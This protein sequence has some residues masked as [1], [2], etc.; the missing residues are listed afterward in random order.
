MKK[1]QSIKQVYNIGYVKGVTTKH[2]LRLDK[3]L[4]ILKKMKLKAVQRILDVGCGDGFFTLK[5]TQQL[6]A[7]ETFGIDISAAAVAEALKRN[8]K[9]SVLDIDESDLPYTSNYF[10]FI[11]CGNLIEVVLDPDHLLAELNRV[12]SPQ[13]YLIITFPNL[14]AW[15]SRIAVLLGFH[16]YFDRISRKYDLGKMFRPCT[17]RDSTGHINLYTLRSF[18][19]LTKIYGFDIIKVYG[20]YA[21]SLPKAMQIIDKIF[22]NL[23]H[24]AFH[25]IS[26]MK[27]SQARKYESS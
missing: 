1:I 3:V 26:I 16:P 2:D 23:P 10:H 14:C 5:L 25:I 18:Q 11:F 8:I 9:A 19:Q 15:A 12:L 7:K 17:R 4:K 22:C 21:N 6:K 20:G 27:K 24:L 13:G